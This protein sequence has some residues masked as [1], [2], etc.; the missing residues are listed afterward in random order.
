MGVPIEIALPG[1]TELD[2]LAI[3]LA[4]PLDD[5]GELVA[6]SGEGACRERRVPR[7][8]RRGA[9]RPHR[10]T[11]VRLASSSSGS[12]SAQTSTST[13]SAPPRAVAA[14]ALARVGGTLGW[15]LDES[16]PIPLADQARALVEGTI[17]GGYTPGRWKTQDTEKLP[18]Q[19]ER[20]VIAHAETQ[21]LREA[22]ERAALA[23]RANEQRA[24]PREH[25][26]E[27]AQSRTRSASTRRRSRAS[28]TT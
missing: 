10:T 12:G 26:A 21:E 23:R 19:I 15:Q 18:R 7:R 6:G 17:L 28:S 1:Q 9:H 22:A 2:A 25:A 5:S 13:P 4:Q 24:R 14:Q 3:P 8:P 20:I 11:T 16:L 27:R